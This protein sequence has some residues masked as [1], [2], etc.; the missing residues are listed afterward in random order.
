VLASL[1][2]APGRRAVWRCLDGREAKQRSSSSSP[3][4]T[5]ASERRGGRRDPLL[6]QARK[7]AATAAG[8]VPSDP[9]SAYVLAY[10][11]ARFACIA[12][13]QA[14]LPR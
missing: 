5:G 13:N 10:D 7:T 12:Q 9:Y 2:S 14:L 1:R 6:E 4:G 3:A 8:L 11:A